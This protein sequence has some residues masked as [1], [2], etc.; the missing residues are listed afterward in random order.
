MKIIMIQAVAWSILLYFSL[1]SLASGQAIILPQ[2]DSELRKTQEDPARE[3]AVRDSRL[4]Q[5]GQG[6]NYRVEGKP[7]PGSS[8]ETEAGDRNDLGRQDTGLNDPTVNP[9]QASGM[10]SV[11]GRIVH[12]DG[13]T[14]TVRQLSGPDTKLTI[15]GST[16]GDKKLIPGDVVTGLVTAQGRA[17]VIHKEVSAKR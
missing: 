2:G 3:E 12:S 7:Q 17:V 8:G 1:A 6:P 11:Q 5:Q 10:Q 14:Y 4:K 13:D 9:G 16:A 15:D